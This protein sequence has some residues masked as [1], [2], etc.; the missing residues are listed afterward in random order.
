MTTGAAAS[1]PSHLDWILRVGVHPL[2]PQLWTHFAAV[3]LY[4]LA[5]RSLPSYPN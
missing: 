4:L 1:A 5:L 3:L 2:L